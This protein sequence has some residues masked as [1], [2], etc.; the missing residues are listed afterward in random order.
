METE[1]EVCARYLSVPCSP[2]PFCVRRCFQQLVDSMCQ[3]TCQ[4]KNERFCRFLAFVR[5]R[6]AF[7]QEV[8]VLKVAL[9]LTKQTHVHPPLLPPS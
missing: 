9:K 1:A 2:L 3:H 8:V 4:H 5:Y 7:C 6:L